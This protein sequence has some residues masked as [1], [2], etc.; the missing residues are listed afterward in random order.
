MSAANTALTGHTV[1]VTRPSHQAGP[2]CR[3]IE[4]AGGTAEAIPALEIIP[5]PDQKTARAELEALRDCD[6]AVFVSA[7]AVDQALD[8]L[9]PDPL[10]GRPALAAVGRGTAAALKARGYADVIH[11]EHR[12]D[13]EGL[14]ETPLFRSVDGRTVA[15]IRGEGGRRWLAEALRG[16]GA[17]VRPIAVYRR[18]LPEQ[19]APALRAAL[20]AGRISLVAISSNAGLD[21]LLTMAGGQYADALRALPA[22]VPSQRTREFARERGFRAPI[23]VAAGAEDKLIIQALGELATRITRR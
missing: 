18:G 17:R 15:I 11:P 20:A 1:L 2:L 3:L 10:P 19:A 22:A 16:A 23:Q 12:F 7:N 13:S 5:R 9:A 4:A 14:L 8:L 21:N 6:I